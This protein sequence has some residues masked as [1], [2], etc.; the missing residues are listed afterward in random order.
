MA[1]LLDIAGVSKSGYYDWKD[2]KDGRL[3][4]EKKD[5]ADFELILEAFNYRGYNKG[6]RSIYMRLLRGGIVMNIKK[7]RRLMK[8]YDLMCPIRKPNPY[9]MALRRE[10]ENKVYKN[11]LNRE[12]KA[13][14][15]RA[16]LLTDIT[17]LYY[18]NGQKCYMSAVKDAFT[19]ECLGYAV[20]Q[21]FSLDFVLE[22]FRIVIRD[23][24]STIKSEAIVHS[25]QGT[26]YTSI[27]FSRL[28]KNMGL[29]R[30]M[31]RKANCWDNAPQESFF[32]HMKDEIGGKI[33]KCKTFNEVKAIVD[34]WVD[35]YNNERY[36]WDLAKLAPSEYY[37]YIITGEYPLRDI[38]VTEQ[39]ESGKEE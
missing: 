19:T 4:R 28:V 33:K 14:G 22:T 29:M 30:S 7:I 8:K 21:N 25:D 38:G 15:A 20:S 2:G 16:V 37:R 24:G 18:W 36:Q 6:A 1:W 31:S 34:D 12:F 39:E 3:K 23:H 26:H 13:H 35:Y 17:Y 11:V 27:R 32:G 5:R 9:R 10:H